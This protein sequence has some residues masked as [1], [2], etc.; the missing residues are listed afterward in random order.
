MSRFFDQVIDTNLLGTIAS[1]RS[2]IKMMRNQIKPGRIILMDGAVPH[3]FLP[4][5]PP[6][7]PGLLFC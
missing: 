4:L 6:V 7:F 2:A 1:V 5:F 3:H